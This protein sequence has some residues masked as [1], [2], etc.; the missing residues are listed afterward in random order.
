MIGIEE[1][2]IEEIKSIKPELLIYFQY[3]YRLKEKYLLLRKLEK[4]NEVSK[5]VLENIDWD[6]LKNKA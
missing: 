4:I 1:F 2:Q 6:K 5:A 3:I